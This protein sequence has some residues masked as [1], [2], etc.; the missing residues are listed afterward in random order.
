MSIQQTTRCRQVI[1]RRD[2]QEG[3][4]AG[5]HIGQA[6]TEVESTKS[7]YKPYLDKSELSK[8]PDVANSTKKA[9]DRL[10]ATRFEAH[11]LMIHK[12]SLLKTSASNKKD[13][14]VE[15]NNWMTNINADI[16]IVLRPIREMV[17]EN[18]AA[19]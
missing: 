14:Y 17:A 12:R 15:L 10:C 16:S 6:M 13:K 8:V 3:R 11:A 2:K 1:D 18:I 9:F 5:S 19:T 4:Q 7:L